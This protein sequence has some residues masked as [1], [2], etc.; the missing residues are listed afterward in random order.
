MAIKLP[1]DFQHFQKHGVFE[2]ETNPGASIIQNLRMLL[3]TTIGDCRFLPHFG[4]PKYE[5]GLNDNADRYPRQLAEAIGRWE[6]RL[7]TVAV[8]LTGTS[9]QE[10][11]ETRPQVIIRGFIDGVQP[12][13]Y[14]FDL[15][16]ILTEPV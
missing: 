13:E 2:Q 10:D 8:D 5:P 11:L 15:M 6:P 4:S 9:D 3:Y 1:L 16:T 7:K 12:F 14:S